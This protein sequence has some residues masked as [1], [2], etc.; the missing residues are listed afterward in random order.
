MARKS[1]IISTYVFI[2]PFSFSGIRTAPNGCK[3]HE[4]QQ[5]NDLKNHHKGRSSP[6]RTLPFGS[7]VHLLPPP[8]DPHHQEPGAPQKL[9]TRASLQLLHL[10][11]ELKA[12]HR[13]VPP[14]AHW[15]KAPTRKTK[16]AVSDLSSL[17]P[18]AQAR[19]EIEVLSGPQRWATM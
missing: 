18:R 14:L 19:F 2:S 11:K 17:L 4:L 1:L 5:E 6:P 16:R 3:P 7:L 13:R 15:R 10:H 8:V 12:A 9:D